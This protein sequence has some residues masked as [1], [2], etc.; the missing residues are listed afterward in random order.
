VLDAARTELRKL[1]RPINEM[2]F[3]WQVKPGA[4]A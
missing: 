4:V 3:R 2:D 1:E